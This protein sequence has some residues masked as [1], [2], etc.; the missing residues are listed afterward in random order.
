[1]PN[2]NKSHALRFTPIPKFKIP[3]HS[4]VAIHTLYISFHPHSKDHRSRKSIRARRVNAAAN[5]METPA[6]DCT[7]RTT[8]YTT[9]CTPQRQ[10]DR[11]R[12]RCTIYTR[13]T[14]RRDFRNRAAVLEDGERSRELSRR[15]DW[16][17]GTRCSRVKRTQPNVVAEYL[18]RRRGYCRPSRRTPLIANVEQPVAAAVWTLFSDSAIRVYKRARV[19]CCSE[20]CSSGRTG[21]AAARVASRVC[22]LETFPELVASGQREPSLAE[23][24]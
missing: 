5:A 3:Q 7:V 13:T 6:V 21:V 9:Y 22:I 19:R 18:C 17:D 4:R 12:R 24:E 20:R 15:G 14:R 16:D 2:K 11:D 8:W 10:K 1:M 23:E